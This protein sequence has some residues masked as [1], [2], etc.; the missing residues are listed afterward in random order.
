MSYIEQV[1]NTYHMAKRN[2]FDSKDKEDRAR[3]ITMY[4]W[5]SDEIRR[6]SIEMVSA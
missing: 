1:Y 2:M 6:C 5:A 3:W 4:C